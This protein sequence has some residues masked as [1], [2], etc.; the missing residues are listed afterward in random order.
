[1]KMKR[2]VIMPLAALL[3][4]SATLAA[5]QD[6]LVTSSPWLRPVFALQ[7]GYAS[8]HVDSHSQSVTGTDLDIFTYHQSGNSTNTGFIGAFVGGE[9]HLAWLPQAGL[10]TQ[11]G[12]EYNY[13][14]S[15]TAKGT[16]TVTMES[17]NATTYDYQYKL[18]T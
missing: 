4:C 8:S 2:I 1:M 6:I 9:H 18:N 13:F 5:D 14:G 16:N 15:L 12:G 17:P 11:F 3:S 7:G 10:F